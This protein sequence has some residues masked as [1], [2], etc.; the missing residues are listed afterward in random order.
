MYV[1]TTWSLFHPHP[2]DHFWEREHPLLAND[3]VKLFI[4]VVDDVED[5][6]TMYERKDVQL[7]DMEKP[8]Q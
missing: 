4:S 5:V 2:G 8:P 6:P 3:Q 7:V 1:E